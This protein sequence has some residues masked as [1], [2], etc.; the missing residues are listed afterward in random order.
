VI[1]SIGDIE[2]RFVRLPFDEA[3]VDLEIACLEAACA[4]AQTPETLVPPR[5]QIVALC[6][7]AR[8][9]HAETNLVGMGWLIWH[10]RAYPCGHK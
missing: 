2:N 7:C 5:E 4:V 3:I 10:A 8:V 1:R 9:A 6:E